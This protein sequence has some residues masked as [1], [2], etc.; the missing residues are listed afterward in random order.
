MSVSS[1]ALDPSASPPDRPSANVAALTTGMVMAR[2]LAAT[3][4]H[5]V[6]GYPG[7]PNIELMEQC[8][9][10]G[11][12]FVLTRREGTAAFMADAFGQLTGLPGVCI[13]TLGPGSTNLVNGVATAW[14]DRTPMLAISGQLST[15]LEPI[16]THQNVDHG[17]LFSPVSKW[18]V[19]M[20]PEAAG[21]IMRKAL[22]VATAERPGPVHITTAANVLGV[23]AGDAEVR[24]PPFAP[25]QE[26]ATAFAAIG[27][28]VEP[29][30]LLERA[31]R[32][33][34]LA[35]IGA[36]RAD[37]G[38]ALRALAEDL[39]CPVVVSPKAKGIC[40]DDHPYYAGTIDMACNK[41]VW[42]LLAAADLILAVGFDA[43][44]L[45]K[46]WRLTVPV[47]HI[48]TTPNTDQVYP[49]DVEFVGALPSVLAAF[50]AAA[51]GGP[52]WTEAAVRQHR[53]E[54]FD[55]YYSG[56][57]AGALNPSDVVD[58]VRDAMPAST[59]ATT[60]VGSHKL[61]VGQGW[62]TG[63]PRS[64]LMTNGL[65]SMGFALPGATTAKLLHR[66]RP[67]V[68]FTGDG[69]F[70]MV[71][72]ELQVAASLGLPLLVVV[73]CDNSL[74]RIE[75]KQLVKHYPSWGTRFAASDTV[76]L[77]EGMGCD[78]ERADTPAALAAIVARAATLTR[79]LVVEAR[80]D[81]SQ[82]VAQF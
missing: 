5:V 68:C 28:S 50:Q 42:S 6:F 54:L 33:V 25:A 62:R 19:A 52:R 26:S 31:R 13:S 45:I 73:F 14:L 72:S 40:P 17:R 30:R 71:Q 57:V 47:V 79:P 7:D 8:R 51:H 76:K 2:Y 3:G 77:A 49:A 66:D 64:L 9:R 34:I 61:L 43:V 18:A 55:E 1:N 70:A 39:G 78:G 75:L 56:R 80:I 20:V 24:L 46:P 32:P 16:F 60:D 15:G 12:Q 67:V 27:R 74:H 65:S 36:V 29:A 48:D 69:G 53:S 38:S 59:I 11:L 35:G 82:Y 81:P 41:K 23:A 37:C 21:A 58:T 63:A 10:A 22:R 44:E 4:I